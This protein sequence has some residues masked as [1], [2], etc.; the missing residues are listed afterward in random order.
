MNLPFGD[1][2]VAQARTDE[3]EDLAFAWRQVQRVGASG[4]TRAHRHRA[5][6]N[7]SHLAAHRLDCGVGAESLEA[8]MRGCEVRSRSGCS[9][10]TDT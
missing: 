9:A 8:A 3:R 2:G 6:A 5:D 7:P 10:Y 1:L 4:P